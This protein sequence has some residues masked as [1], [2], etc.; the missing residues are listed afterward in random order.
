MIGI[1]EVGRGALAGPVV[2]AAMRASGR[3]RWHH[4]ILGPIR[5]SKRL[6]PRQREIWFAYLTAHPSL[7]WRVAWLRPQTIDRI[8]IAAATNLGARRLVERMLAKGEAG[9]V[10]LDGGLVLP[11]HIPH[12]SV[13]K[14]DERIP[15]I[16]AASI[17]AKVWRDRLMV[18]LA[19]TYPDYGF[20][21]HKG[22]GTRLHYECL[23]RAGP[24]KVHRRSF[25]A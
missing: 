7:E 5:D 18:R 15:V 2:L 25:L 16:A 10:W 8:N 21:I 11:E 1:D 14:G 9:F 17:M 23:R 3:V 6:T 4:P 19:R 24:S 20:D 12:R 13:I 22:Y